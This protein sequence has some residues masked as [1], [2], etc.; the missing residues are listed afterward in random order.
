M[1]REEIPFKASFSLLEKKEKEEKKIEKGW[2][3]EEV[4]NETRW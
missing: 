1:Q 2:K 3:S 4:G